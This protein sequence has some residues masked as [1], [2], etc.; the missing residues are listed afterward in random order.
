MYRLFKSKMCYMGSSF[1]H[2]CPYQ[3]LTNTNTPA[4]AL[5][6]DDLSMHMELLKQPHSRPRPRPRP[7]PRS[8]SRSRLRLRQRSVVVAIARAIVAASAGAVLW[9][10]LKCGH[11]I[12]RVLCVLVV[13]VR[14][15]LR[16]LRSP[17]DSSKL[18]SLLS[19]VCAWRS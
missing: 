12:L 2:Y 1:F 9:Q 19:M 6:N 17:L 3:H 8:R 4:T 18:R 13:E 7:R 14:D 10:D 11:K 16:S 5:S 15:I